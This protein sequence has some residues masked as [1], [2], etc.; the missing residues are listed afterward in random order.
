MSNVAVWITGAAGSVGDEVAFVKAGGVGLVTSFV[1]LAVDPAFV[2]ILIMG[3]MGSLT[4]VEFVDAAG[5][6]VTAGSVLVDAIGGIGFVT[7]LVEASVVAF[8]FFFLC[9]TGDGDAGGVAAALFVVPVYGESVDATAIVPALNKIPNANPKQ[10][11]MY[12]FAIFRRRL[13]TNKQHTMERSPMGNKIKGLKTSS[14]PKTYRELCN[15]LLPRKIHDDSELEA[16]KEI[17]DVLAVLPTRTT[18][19]DDYLET[20]A[21]LVESYEEQTV[22][23]SQR[24]GLDTLKFLLS[25]NNLTASDLSRL[26][27]TDISL[28]YRILD[29]DRNLTTKH[30]KKLAQQFHVGPEVF[31]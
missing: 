24:S 11:Q 27:D 3:G 23:I 4:A 17:I 16:T 2:S 13:C 19:Q 29:G 12:R 21:E 8:A 18:D 10:I 9:L 26:L 1:E 6:S 30:I 31:L 7:L 22:K 5:G 25:E 15:L 28:G 14:L 20:L